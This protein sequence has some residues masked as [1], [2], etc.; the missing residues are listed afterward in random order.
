MEAASLLRSLLFIPLAGVLLIGLLPGRR[1]ALVRGIALA[2]TSASF[3]YVI[4]LYSQFDPNFAG[5]QFYQSHTWNPR[6]GSAFVLAI[7]GISLIML[8]LASLLGLMAVLA[9][10]GIRQRV[11]AYYMLLLIAQGLMLGVFLARDWS[12][13]YA[14]WQLSL[15]PL[16]FLIRHWGGAD[17]HRAAFNF[18]LYPL[19]GSLFILL[20]LLMLYDMVPGQTVFEMTLM[21][22]S[23]RELP[24]SM[25]IWLFLCFL[26]GFGVTMAI[27]PLHGWAPLAQ[28]GAAGPVAILLAGVVF[29]MG[30]YGLIRAASML[31][32]AMAALQGPLSVLALAGLIYG[33]VL[34]WNQRTFKAMIAYASV[35]SMALALLGLTT[36]NNAG[37]T[38]AVL[39]LVAHGL[40][41]GALFL[42][43]E[44]LE[45]HGRGRPGVDEAALMRAMPRFAVVTV[46]ALFTAIGLPGTAGFIALLHVLIGGFQAWGGWIALLSL[47]LLISASYV[48]RSVGR[49]LAPPPAS[50][51]G[52]L[53]DLTLTGLATAVA[54]IGASLLIGLYPTPLL[55]LMGSSVRR[56][57]QLFA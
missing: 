1:M 29:K 13:F 27:F 24:E 25:Q 37:I 44:W 10:S 48:L 11:K 49:L 53:P 55:E 43:A 21:R 54:L 40:V 33:A 2:T 34:A 3:G 47:T 31:P 4:W 8:L 14:F 20:A 19:A 17:R 41:V 39:Q 6:L 51:A 28:T 50:R 42:L 23:G 7:D 30:T 15:I 26:V 46:L 22:E 5:V 45:G 9:S 38:G 36:L 56:L 12:M 18:A 32:E 57:A 35:S 16:F 52:S